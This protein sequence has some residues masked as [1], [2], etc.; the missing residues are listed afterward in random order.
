MASGEFEVIK[1]VAAGNAERARDAARSARAEVEGAFAEGKG[2]YEVMNLREFAVAFNAET[3]AGIWAQ[4]L[5]RIEAVEAELAEDAGIAESVRAGLPADIAIDGIGTDSFAEEGARLLEELGN[6]R[7]ELIGQVLAGRASLWGGPGDEY[8]VERV[9]EQWV[10]RGG[11][12]TRL[13]AT[14]RGMAANSGRA[15]AAA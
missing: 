1:S 10:Q 13:I 14:V 15:E 11:E 7:E 2:L 8:Y 5:E 6:L 12:L 9:R 4:I 3:D